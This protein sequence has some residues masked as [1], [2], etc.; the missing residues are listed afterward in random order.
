MERKELKDGVSKYIQLFEE[1]LYD[2]DR[3][4]FAAPRTLS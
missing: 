3:F 4:S 1:K 2:E